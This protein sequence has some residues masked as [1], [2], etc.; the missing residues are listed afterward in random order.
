ML[1]ALFQQKPLSIGTNK[2]LLFQVSEINSLTRDA[3]WQC[4]SI[5][6]SDKLTV[7]LLVSGYLF[8][9]SLIVAGKSFLRA[10]QTL[11]T[12]ALRFVF[13]ALSFTTLL[14]SVGI[15]LLFSKYLLS[16][17]INTGKPWNI[18]KEF[19]IAILNN[20][21]LGMLIGSIGAFVI[22][23]CIK[24]YI[25][26]WFSSLIESVS[27]TV[28]EYY[29]FP[30]FDNVVKLLPKRPKS[31]NFIAR[32]LKSTKGKSLICVGLSSAD[33][34]ILID[35]KVATHPNYQ[36]LGLTGTGKG[37][38]LG[39]FYLQFIQK[40]CAC[41]VFCPKEDKPLKN[42][43]RF[44]AK[45]SEK[46]F[47]YLNLCASHP[48]VNPLFNITAR[49][50]FVLLKMTFELQSSSEGLGYY[51]D[52]E[53]ELAQTLS[54]YADSDDNP[55]LPGLLHFA[56]TLRDT[57]SK[58]ALGLF[59]KLKE[60]AALPCVATLDGKCITEVIQ[61]GGCVV[62]EGN[63]E[64]ESI[65]LVMKLLLHRVAQLTT[66]RADCSRKVCIALDEVKYTITTSVINYMG[67]IRSFGGCFHVTQQSLA[68]FESVQLRMPPDA[69]RESML[70]NLPFKIIFRSNNYETALRVSNLCGTVMKNEEVRHTAVNEIASQTNF[71]ERRISRQ[72][73]PYVHPNIV[74]NLPQSCAIAIG[75]F[76]RPTYIFVPILHC[77]STYL[78]TYKASPINTTDC[79]NNESLEDALL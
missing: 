17:Y 42:V 6:T 26:P 38:F 18:Y 69:V 22:Y 63:T 44:S 57:I 78:E 20:A 24:R 51:K 71:L 70:D 37:Q 48:V 41:F 45:T 19:C 76:E 59:I 66:S 40:K 2:L 61:K 75:I 60:I 62:I 68:D 25:E 27:K 16:S 29:D 67:N 73:V 5:A 33:K 43:L 39:L 14:A 12:R 79:L 15:V 31:K 23:F 32:V 53:R 1:E 10:D 3:L 34:P 11:I 77:E 50:L 4:L 58:D 52:V 65:L 9:I 55:S 35:F 8:A 21:S 64:D 46:P 72:E 54:A 13:S 7:T 74:Q 30:D 28:N 47:F 56:N 36:T 49:E